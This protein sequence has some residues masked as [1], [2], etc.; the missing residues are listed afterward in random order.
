MGYKSM[1]SNSKK[2]SQLRRVDGLDDDASV[3]TGDFGPASGPA[4]GASTKPGFE[5]L[6]NGIGK[7]AKK[8]HKFTKK[9]SKV[10]VKT[11]LSVLA[12]V[13]GAIVDGMTSAADAYPLSY[14]NA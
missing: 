5:R 8:A 7:A 4:P 14:P 3:S 13:A 10:I 11:T 2:A 1:A 12:S 6:W 9:H